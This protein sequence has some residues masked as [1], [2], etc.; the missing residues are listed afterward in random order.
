MLIVTKTFLEGLTSV[1]S[2]CTFPLR[3][4]SPSTRRASW[5]WTTRAAPTHSQRSARLSIGLPHYI[6]SLVWVIN[7]PSEILA[8]MAETTRRSPV[9][10][11]T[12]RLARVTLSRPILTLRSPTR[13]TCSCSSSPWPSSSAPA[14]SVSSAHGWSL[15]TSRV[16]VCNAQVFWQLLA[17]SHANNCQ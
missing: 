6:L 14:S 8:K 4:T 10:P 7:L 16:S 5:R 12:T 3:T 11:A 13:S 17:R 15:W 1:S 2:L 9:S